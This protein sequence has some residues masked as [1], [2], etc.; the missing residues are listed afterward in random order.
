MKLRTYRIHS[1]SLLK[2]THVFADLPVET[3]SKNKFPCFN[4]VDALSHQKCANSTSFNGELFQ[5]ST[6]IFPTT[7]LSVS[8]AL[9]IS[10]YPSGNFS[11]DFFA[12][13]SMNFLQA[14]PRSCSRMTVSAALH[15][16]RLHLLKETGWESGSEGSAATAPLDIADY[17]ASA[18]GLGRATVWAPALRWLTPSLT[19][20]ALPIDCPLLRSAMVSTYH[21][22]DTTRVASMSSSM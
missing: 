20:T 7:I 5:I 14:R 9:T 13:G 19:W 3:I 4:E 10:S 1:K 17:G 8:S 15:G 6:K 21:H 2:H 16:A 18:A 11:G 22:S 12:C